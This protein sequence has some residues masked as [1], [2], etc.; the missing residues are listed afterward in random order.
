MN[1]KNLSN[2]SFMYVAITLMGVA[3]SMF[4]TERLLE[5]TLF[6]LATLVV[7]VIREKLKVQ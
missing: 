6:S 4:A 3:S 7:L 2:I 1:S 5:G